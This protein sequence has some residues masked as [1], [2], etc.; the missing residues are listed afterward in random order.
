MKTITFKFKNALDQEEMSKELME[1]IDLGNISGSY[2]NSDPDN[3][4]VVLE[5]VFED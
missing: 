3:I 2:D 4:V 5:E 1:D